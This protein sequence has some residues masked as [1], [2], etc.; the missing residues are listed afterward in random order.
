MRA[1]TW[2]SAR[3]A[4]IAGSALALAASI[5]SGAMPE[6]L[7]I[8]SSQAAVAS[9]PTGAEPTTGRPAAVNS[10]NRCGVEW[11]H[12][13]DGGAVKRAVQVAPFA[14]RQLRRQRQAHRC[15]Q[16]IDA[17]RVGGETAHRS[18]RFSC[19]RPSGA[20]GRGTAPR[21]AS[22]R[23]YFSMAPARTSFASAC[24]G[25]PK[26]GTSMPIMR[27]PSHFLRQ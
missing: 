9:S 21:S 18:A 5:R 2:L 12:R 14:G 8:A 15:Q 22:V 17:R 13:R 6:A 24:V 23:A 3:T 11:V 20:R 25:T 4:L 26:P 1:L 19:P 10:L 27:T 16:C 7:P